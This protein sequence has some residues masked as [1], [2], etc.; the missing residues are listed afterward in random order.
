VK[1]AIAEFRTVLK[2]KSQLP[3]GVVHGDLNSLNIIG[4]ESPSG[5]GL[6]G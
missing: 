2:N 5:T 1:N 3:A 4:Q 6:M